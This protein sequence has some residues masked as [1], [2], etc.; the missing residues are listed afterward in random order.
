MNAP[1]LLEIL[2]IVLAILGFG[3]A[4]SKPAGQG[5]TWIVGLVIIPLTGLTGIES[6]FFNKT[7][8]KIKGREAGWAYQTQSGSIT[9]DPERTLLIMKLT[10]C[11]FA[12]YKML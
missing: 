5:L 7:A 1:K 3:V 8:A 12:A 4:Y 11:Y 6:V 2:R 10:L 9:Q